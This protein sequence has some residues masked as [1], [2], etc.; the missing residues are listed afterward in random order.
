MVNLTDLHNHILYGVDDG[1]DSLETSLEIIKQEYEQGVRNIILTPHFHIGECMPK[2]EKMQEHFEV[3]Q[4][5]VKKQYPDMKLYLGNE[6][7]ACNDMPDLLEEGRIL[8]L[9]GS[10]YVLVEFYPTVREKEME[11]Y[12]MDLISGGYIPIIAHCE[13]YQ[14]LR[15]KIGVINREQILHLIEM[16]VYF[17]VNA[18]SLLGREKKFVLKMMKENF[19]YFI[20][21][22]A[23][24]TGRRGVYWDECLKVLE[25][26]FTPGYLQ[27]LLVDNPQKV[28][29]DKYL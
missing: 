15:K 21:T 24:S 1:S 29:E 12:L 5:A 6:V 2:Q 10:R 18:T 28:I 8:S 9:A 11:R 19:L 7:M 20:A 22:D 26:K 3:L 27:W 23:H 25:K 13:R 14:C 4:K 16:G 17:Q